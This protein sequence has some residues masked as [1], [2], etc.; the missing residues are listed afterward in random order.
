MKEKEKTSVEYFERIGILENEIIEKS[1]HIQELEK[2]K[3]NLESHHER[4]KVFNDKLNENIIVFKSKLVTARAELEA[5]KKEWQNERERLVSELE[6]QK[7]R[8][9]DTEREIHEIFEAKLEKKKKEMV[10]VSYCLHIKNS[11]MKNITFITHHQSF[12]HNI[13][14]FSS[15]Q[16]IHIKIHTLLIKL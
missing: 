2:E 14:F 6:V 5:G 9:I 10:R 3:L 16:F 11:F 8:S 15:S 13:L 7:Q 12:T 1:Q 4:E